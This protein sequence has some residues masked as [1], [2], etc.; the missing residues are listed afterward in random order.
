MNLAD[1]QKIPTE[2]KDYLLGELIYS[3]NLKIIENF[4]LTNKQADFVLNL[5]NRVILKNISC[6]D[7]PQE[8]EEINDGSVDVRGLV[9][10]LAINIFWPIQDYL[11]NVDRLILRLGGKVP[12]AQHLKSLTLQK[13]LFPG[14]ANGVVQQLMEDYDDFS[15][16]RLTSKKLMGPEGQRLT[17]TVD[18]WFKDYVHYLGA[19]YHNSLQRAQ[20]L[21]KSPNALEL[22]E[23]ERESLR[24]FL[25]SY[26]EKIVI[27]IENRDGVLW[28][29]MKQSRESADTQAVDIETA[30]NNLNINLDK[31]DKLILPENFIMSEAKDDVY[32]VYDMLWEA[33]GLGDKEKVFS[34]LKVLVSRKFLDNL[35]ISDNRF[36]SILNRFI[37]VRY[38]SAFVGWLDQNQDKL[39][40][41]RLFL[42]MLLMDKLRL[43][44]EESAVV[45]LYL[46]SQWP[47]SGQ[48]TYLDQQDGVLK[49][50]N[51][52]ANKNQL[53]WLDN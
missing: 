50:R 23:Q 40:A 27:D 5:E 13:K 3:N 29:S 14:T 7:I 44:E 51:L 32:K 6:L 15:E 12:K 38:G 28:G 25:L 19:G 26:D 33:L 35:I 1:L 37:T 48:V 20:Y 42:E 43:S 24:C 2:I 39:L 4:N 46:T 16:F 47:Q 17:P 11:G 21:A 45:A 22:D 18:N 8:I 34:C 41:R 52:Q 49:W 9:L 31:L 53:I 30:V 10:E 36:K